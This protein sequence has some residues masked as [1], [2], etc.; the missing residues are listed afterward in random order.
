MEIRQEPGKTFSCRFW[1]YRNG[2]KRSKYQT[3]F[4]RKKDAERWG[5][6]EKD[7]MERLQNG[8]EHITVSAFLE[9]WM[10]VKEKK[11]SP[12]TISGYRVNIDH[13]N[14]YIGNI[15]LR[16][17]L[18]MDVQEMADEL[19]DEGLKYRTVKYVCRTLHVALNYAVKNRI[20]DYNPSDGVE[21]SEDDEE[22]EAVIYKPEHLNELLRL[23]K[24]QEHPLYI[25]VL[26]ASMRGLRRGEALGLAWD[27]IDFDTGV[28]NIHNNY[29]IVNGITYDRAVKSKD[30]K[31]FTVISGFVMDE[32]KAYREHMRR[33]GQLQ[34]YVCEID[35]K[36]PNPSHV[37]LSL[38]R[39]QVA[40]NLPVCRFHDLRHTFAM[41]QLE[42][43]TDLDTLKNLMGHSK[44]EITSDLYLHPSLTLMRDATSKVDNIITLKKEETKE[45]VTILS[46]S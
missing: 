2:R 42:N 11:L 19:T 33:N 32:L 21:I 1:Y 9:R 39:F 29:V 12:T 36:R 17:L 38:K 46:Q 16:N 10:N 37:S 24:E 27:D 6:G 5:N 45:N 4:T 8:A 3:G 43:G 20:I 18:L 41:M 35:G 23:L 13:I 22:F 25:P 31:R 44:I 34:K 30:S 26:L 7:R 40:S 15:Q 28:T 14:E